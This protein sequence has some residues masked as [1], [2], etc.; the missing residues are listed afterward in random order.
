MGNS[1][2]NSNKS[3][4]LIAIGGALAVTGGLM[5]CKKQQ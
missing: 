5:Y 1:S 2:N 3:N 4:L